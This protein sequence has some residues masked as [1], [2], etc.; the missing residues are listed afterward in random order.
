MKANR[1]K[2]KR[3]NLEIKADWVK[4]IIILCGNEIGHVADVSAPSYVA[5]AS[6]LGSFPGSLVLWRYSSSFRSFLSF[7]YK[8]WLYLLLL[9]LTEAAAT[10]GG[11]IRRHGWRLH[12]LAARKRKRK[13]RLLGLYSC[14]FIMICLLNCSV[15][16]CLVSLTR[17]CSFTSCILEPLALLFTSCPFCSCSWFLCFLL[18]LW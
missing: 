14:L 4:F 11:S 2:V 17:Y 7:K 5:A 18:C 3:Y 10:S 13:R 15:T 1:V 9:W 8:R 6:K 16:V 12:C